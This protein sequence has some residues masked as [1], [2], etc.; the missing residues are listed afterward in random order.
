VAPAPPP[1]PPAVSALDGARNG[2]ASTEAAALAHHYFDQLL[3]FDALEAYT[4]T[5]GTERLGFSVARKW[6]DGRV[7]LAIKV[8]EPRALDELVILLLQNRERSD[9][10]FVYLTP[11]LFPDGGFEALGPGGR[12]RRLQMSGLDFEVPFTGTRFPMGE[13]RPFLRGELRW[14]RRPDAVL[15]DEPSYVVEGTPTRGGFAFDSIELVLSKET[16]VALRTRYLVDGDAARTIL[17]R[18]RDVQAR[19]GRWLPIRRQVMGKGSR[20]YELVL[21]NVV[22]DPAIPDRMFSSQNLRMKRF[23][24]F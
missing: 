16:G 7:R 22:V 4:A 9:D 17:V 5:A 8:E 24:R 14:E 15:F 3:G 23:P 20:E 11:Q 10:L 21:R 6:Y 1:S 2:S 12:V 13:L 19:Q 18:P